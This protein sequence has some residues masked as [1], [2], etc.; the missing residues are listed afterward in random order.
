MGSPA[1]DLDA[2]LDLQSEEVYVRQEHGVAASLTVVAMARAEAIAFSSMRRERR[3]DRE[4]QLW[5]RLIIDDVFVDMIRA[6]EVDS[7]DDPTHVTFLA[8]FQIV[9]RYLDGRRHRARVSFVNSVSGVQPR[10][11]GGDESVQ[12]DDA[13]QALAEADFVASRAPAH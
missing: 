5:A 3:A 11:A 10:G 9:P 13:P 4:Q 8:R 12:L 1:T 2:D 6:L 7:G